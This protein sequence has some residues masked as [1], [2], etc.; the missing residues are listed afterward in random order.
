MIIRPSEEAMTHAFIR[1]IITGEQLKSEITQHK[2]EKEAA[3]VAKEYR[4]RG[5]QKGAR[6]THLAEIP[7]REYLQMVQK[8]GEACWSDR[9]FIRDFQKHEPTLASNKI[10]TMVEI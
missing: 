7:Q 4:D 9:E 8:Y 5:R 3:Q 1:E 10:S 2:R 6:M